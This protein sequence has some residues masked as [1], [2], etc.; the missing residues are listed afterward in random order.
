MTIN[1]P[2]PATAP[3]NYPKSPD[4]MFYAA[5]SFG[6]KSHSSKTKVTASSQPTFR[7]E[8]QQLPRLLCT[9]LCLQAIFFA[10]SLSWFSDF[11]PTLVNSGRGD[12]FLSRAIMA[13]GSHTSSFTVGCFACLF[14]R[15]CLPTNLRVTRGHILTAFA[16]LSVGYFLICFLWFTAIVPK[17]LVVLNA[18]FP[19]SALDAIKEQT[20]HYDVLSA[21]DIDHSLVASG[22]HTLS[23][24]L[25]MIVLAFHHNIVSKR[26][27]QRLIAFTTVFAVAVTGANM[28]PTFV[29]AM[30]AILTV[31]LL[32]LR[33]TASTKLNASTAV[34]FSVA[35]ASSFTRFS[36]TYNLE[37]KIVN[38]VTWYV[39]TAMEPNLPFCETPF[40]VSP[41]MAQGASA[42]AH[43]PFV[44]SIILALSSIVP[45]LIPS[46]DPNHPKYGKDVAK[47][48]TMLWLQWWLQFYSSLGGHM[49]PNP[50][51]TANQEVCISL[52]FSL[53]FALVKF[54]S[55]R[56]IISWKLALGLTVTPIVMY[57]TIG[58]MPIVFISFFSAMFVGT[59]FKG[60]F[61]RLTPYAEKCLLWT[62][63][64]TI[65][66][67]AVET[68]GCDYLQNEVSRKVPWHFAFDVLFWQVVGS[69]LD[70]VIVSP[71]GRFLTPR[72][73]AG[74]VA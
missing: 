22:S 45:E 6:K 52:A 51:V 12:D 20:R 56:D 42:I 71:P 17:V 67:L 8:V 33:S 10:G 24:L 49:M 26:I 60:A 27:L 73:E 23:W 72:P 66:V 5:S 41:W 38:F 39:D 15:A 40:A 63:V 11:L 21:S 35:C 7:V 55:D 30:L 37:N 4:M 57:L 65:A 29:C 1:P 50:R 46:L 53:L 61:E 13:A 70:V 14:L 32:G 68:F 43:L 59:Q 62:F 54:T 69:A 34:C 2:P 9:A 31:L 64:P 36:S 58:L 28:Q 44:P 3:I 25:G 47:I 16:S 48:R 19:D 74:K 18:A